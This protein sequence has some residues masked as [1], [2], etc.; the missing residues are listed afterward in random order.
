MRLAQREQ[1][2]FVKWLSVRAHPKGRGVPSCPLCGQAEWCL[3]DTVI[4]VEAFKG[5]GRSRRPANANP[6]SC[7]DPLMPLVPLACG[8]CGCT[9][10]FNAVLTGIVRLGKRRARTTEPLGRALNLER[11]TAAP[12]KESGGGR[13]G[14]SAGKGARRRAK[15]VS[16]GRG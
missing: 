3:S 14:I 12:A 6:R 8:R 10:L 11:I 9:L 13:D 2:K 5:T 7:P 16:R 15:T 4:Q 1:E